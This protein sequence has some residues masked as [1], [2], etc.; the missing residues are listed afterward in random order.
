MWYIP[1]ERLLNVSVVTV[2]L[3]WVLKR[4][5]THVY[6]HL[7]VRHDRVYA[8][9]QLISRNANRSQY[10]PN[11]DHCERFSAYQGWLC[12]TWL[13]PR[14][15]CPA[16]VHVNGDRIQQRFWRK[17]RTCPRLILLYSCVLF[18]WRRRC[19]L[20]CIHFSDKYEGMPLIKGL[21]SFWHVVG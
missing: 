14:W 6:Y 3:D 8:E 16:G 15:N 20:R 2:G 5:L 10:W 13:P 11:K 7:A 21:D 17:W 19:T 12:V 1:P 18:C 9:P 4:C